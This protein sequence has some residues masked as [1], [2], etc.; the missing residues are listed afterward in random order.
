MIAVQPKS[1]QIL[2]INQQAYQALRSALH[3][4]LRRQLFIAVCDS[5]VLQE[6]LATQ[7]EE[8]ILLNSRPTLN[9]FEADIAKADGG[10]G[11]P[12]TGVGAVTVLNRLAFEP[13][14][15]HLPRQVVRW[16]HQSRQ[17][18]N[19]L[20]QLQILGIEQMTRQP[21]IVQNHF[22]RSLE[23]ID[24]LLPRLNASLLVWV[25]WPWLRTIQESAPTFWRWRSGV[26]EFVGDPTPT[27][28][29]AASTNSASRSLS[30]LLP[31]TKETVDSRSSDSST[32]ADSLAATLNGE[33]ARLSVRLHGETDDWD[34]VETD[35]EAAS[36]SYSPT[37]S[38]IGL[39]TGAITITD[40]DIEPAE[41]RATLQ[42]AV[43]DSIKDPS[44]IPSTVESAENAAVSLP[45]PAEAAAEVTE[46]VTEESIEEAILEEAV[47]EGA[48][49]EESILEEALQEVPVLEEAVPIES[50]PQAATVPS[51]NGVALSSEEISSE[52]I[53]SEET[54]EQT[55]WQKTASEY[56]AVAYQ[57]RSLIEAG[58]RTLVAIEPAIAAYEA[59][60]RCVEGDYPG[61][62]SCL[63]DLGTLYWLRAQQL[64]DPQSITD[65]MVHSIQLYSQALEQVDPQ[66]DPAMVCQ[67]YS[68]M[69][70]VY[71]L[72]AAYKEPADCFRQSVIVYSRASAIS[73]KTAS[74]QEHAMLCNSLGSVYWKLS[75]YDEDEQKIE[76]HLRLA[77]E[78]YQQALP[79]Y[80][81][82]TQP[83]DYAA[84]QNNIGIT[85]WSLAKH[86]SSIE[87]YEWAIAAYR[88]ALKYRTPETDPAACAI[89][90]NNLALAYWDLSK[91]DTVERTQK[92]TYQQNAV[93]AFES[94]LSIAAAVNALSDMDSAAIYHCLGDVYM[95][96]VEITAATDDI[97][98]TLQ[99][100]LYSYLQSIDG[101]T[102]ESPSFQPRVAAI[103][104]NLQFHYEYIGLSGQ[105]N[106]LNQV[107]PRL[108]PYVMPMLSSSS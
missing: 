54:S 42:I 95:Q 31:N 7:L 83:L 68:N 65:C 10:I 58:D 13:E 27:P 18:E 101:V 22:L 23:K 49:T 43:P 85:H 37:S 20:S 38:S 30:Y 71:S 8:D 67:L 107:P 99:K 70:A 28:I 105:Q 15:A 92:C 106:A 69:G 53:S 64:S 102:E 66:R 63:N 80:D 50:T 36:D 29:E 108:I 76:Q 1:R 93:A 21:A 75:H 11:T 32:V 90:H 100:S 57:R 40:T 46:E 35:N 16:I 17:S 97:A 2:G 103:V 39:S 5:V 81:P 72:L 51:Q 84:V 94:A 41:P 25:S 14:D 55:S 12:Y 6:Q 98:E 86:L 44:T 33:V 52:E 9:H 62:G 48:F 4:N 47:L 26:Y 24:A 104:A 89:T 74:P 61:L 96:M 73:V 88:D 59:G 91:E 82:N 87:M 45:E 56:F 34:D 19:N 3:L 78:A 60:L 77:I 79:G